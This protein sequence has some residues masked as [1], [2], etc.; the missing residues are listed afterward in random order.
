MSDGTFDA[1]SLLDYMAAA[2]LTGQLAAASPEERPTD[3]ELATR[4]YAI[5]AAMMKARQKP[6][7]HETPPSPEPATAATVRGNVRQFKD[8]WPPH[9]HVET[10]INGTHQELSRPYSSL[11]S[12]EIALD[13]TASRL[14][15]EANPRVVQC[16][17]DC[18]PHKSD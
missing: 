16:R 4:S 15:D 6:A 1:I 9:Y 5:A 14:P 13:H 10:V 12:V 17:G 18:P 3:A 2:A 8:N 11:R 7:Q